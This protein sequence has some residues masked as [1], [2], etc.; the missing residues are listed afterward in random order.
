[1]LSTL[2]TPLESKSKSK[3]KSELEYKDEVIE[4][5]T[6]EHAASECN[7]TVRVSESKVEY[8]GI[9]TATVRE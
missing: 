3:S 7:R 6:A 5:E 8:F 2:C 4:V 1:M 9:R